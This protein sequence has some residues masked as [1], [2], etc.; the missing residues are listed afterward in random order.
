MYVQIM[1]LWLC[2]PRGVMDGVDELLEL[3]AL[4]LAQRARLLVAS[5]HV[6]VH[7]CRH[8]V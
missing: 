3:C 4:V 5:G 1:I 6:D 7:V 2:L 8:Y